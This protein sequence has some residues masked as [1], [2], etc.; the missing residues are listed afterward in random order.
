[1]LVQRLFLALAALIYGLGL[2]YGYTAFI[3][4]LLSFQGEIDL[5]PGADA[6]II[7]QTLAVLPALFLP[8]QR[9]S[10][11]SLG[12]AITYLVV[13]IP[14]CT[15]ALHVIDYAN[16]GYFLFMLWLMVCLALISVIV[17]WGTTDQDGDETFRSRRDRN[18]R[19]LTLFSF[20]VL[21]FAIVVEA[22]IISV[23]GLNLASIGD[24]LDL[25]YLNRETVFDRI[26]TERLG[27]TQYLVFAQ[28]DVVLPMLFALGVYRRAWWLALVAILGQA[29]VGLATAQKGAFG[30]AALQT[31]IYIAWSGMVLPRIPATLRLVAGAAAGV[32][33]V[34]VLYAL[35]GWEDPMILSVRR[36]LTANGVLTAYYFDYFSKADFVYYAQTLASL[37]GQYVWQTSYTYIIGS[38]MSPFANSA[39]VNFWGDAYANLGFLGVLLAS[40][41][42]ALILLLVDS[43]GRRGYPEFVALAFVPSIF[44]VCSTGLQTSIITGGIWLM[45]LLLAL[46]P[47]RVAEPGRV[48]EKK[49]DALAA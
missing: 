27:G 37:G 45:V 11:A 42:F 47:R 7:G 3:S 44:N 39:N 41:L 15:V 46:L 14:C 17:R 23:F 49:L 22:Y 13:Y 29:G 35:T 40:L 5:N 20:A 38:Y 26:Y 16:N 8:V 19:L 4:P 24:F 36:T 34:L 30:Y 6:W 9:Q 10:V 25:M 1:M 43:F 21:A 2:Q 48:A 31:V 32:W 12:V 18:T 28:R 33:A